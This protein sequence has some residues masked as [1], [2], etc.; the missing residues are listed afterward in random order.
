MAGAKGHPKAGGR[1]KGTP[2]KVTV[3]VREAAKETARLIEETV[4]GAF[5]GDAHAYLMSVYKDPKHPIEIRIDAAKAAVRYEK[6]SLAA[7]QVQGD[8]DKP[9]T[10]SREPMSMEE[11]AKKF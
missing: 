9:L 5:K 4:P 3:A 1:Q 7:V 8:K 2:N 10:F 11:W 6:P